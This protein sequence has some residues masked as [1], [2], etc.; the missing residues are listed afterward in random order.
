MKKNYTLLHIVKT[1]GDNTGS[2]NINIIWKYYIRR[3]IRIFNEFF[4]RREGITITIANCDVDSI[5]RCYWLLGTSF[6]LTF[7]LCPNLHVWC[8]MVFWE[9]RHKIPLTP[10]THILST[11]TRT[12]SAFVD[13]SQQFHLIYFYVHLEIMNMHRG[14]D[15]LLSLLTMHAKHNIHIHSYL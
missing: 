9:I 10:H 6:S 1:G 5:W 13:Y 8:V 7:M 14:I 4:L 11:Y 2:K 15:E 12:H 3:I